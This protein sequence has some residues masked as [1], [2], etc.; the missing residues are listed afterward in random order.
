MKTLLFSQTREK[1]SYEKITVA[2]NGIEPLSP[3]YASS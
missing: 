3:K 1:Q 2:S